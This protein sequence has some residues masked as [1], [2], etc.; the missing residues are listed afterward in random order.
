[1]GFRLS[2]PNLRANLEKDLQAVCE[3]QKQPAEVLRQQVSCYKD[4]FVQAQ[5]R[6]SVLRSSVNNY[7]HLPDNELI[8]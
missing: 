7:I 8:V 4:I 2:K 6:S 3:G 5:Q 1:M